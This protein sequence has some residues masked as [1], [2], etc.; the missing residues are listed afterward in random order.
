M[1]KHILLFIIFSVFLQATYIRTNGTV[2]DTETGLMW[3]DDY[4][5]NDGKIKQT[6]WYNAI[7]YCNNLDALGYDDWRLPNVNELASIVDDTKGTEPFHIPFSERSIHDIFNIE[8]FQLTHLP[9]FFTSTTFANGVGDAWGVCFLDGHI[10]RHAKGET[11]RYVRCVRG[12]D[13]GTTPP[14]QTSEII[15]DNHNTEFSTTGTWSESSAPDEYDGS[16]LYSKTLNSSAT[17]TPT[18]PEAGSYQVYVW[19]SGSSSHSRDTDADYTVNYA[20]G[21]ETI[22]ID[23][24][25]GSGDWVLLGL[26]PF[27]AGSDGNVTLL[28]DIESE[29][30]S[31]SA[32][33]VKFEPL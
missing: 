6:N 26:F 25:Q 3:Q 19:Y 9:W 31:T 22:V 4:S 24:S 17:W 27:N 12:S 14:P 13:G 15:V 30:I 28:R 18:L 7:S 16:S 23:Q 10:S 8:L 21:S 29:S 32:D 2:S 20:G 5:D 1:K 33:A 11:H